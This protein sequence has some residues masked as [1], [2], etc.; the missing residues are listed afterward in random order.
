MPVMWEVHVVYVEG[1]C[2]W[3]YM[4][5]GPS[6]LGE[7][8]LYR[9]NSCTKYELQQQL[10]HCQRLIHDLMNSTPDPNAFMSGIH[11][12]PVTVEANM[13]YQ[14]LLMSSHPCPA[15]VLAVQGGMCSVQVHL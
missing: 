12:F 10:Q 13:S 11:Y 4:L 6:F 8:H 9:C 2:I 1:A 5:G 3:R 15:A 7:V 14:G